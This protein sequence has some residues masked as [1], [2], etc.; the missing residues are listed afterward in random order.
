MTRVLAIATRAVETALIRRAGK[1]RPGGVCGCIVTVI[2]HLGSG[3]LNVYLHMLVLDGANANERGKLRFGPLP[4]SA[5]ALMTLL[6]ADNEEHEV[7]TAAC[8]A[9]TAAGLSV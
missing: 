5:P 1:T 4:P 8:K 9:C 3:S 7:G 2:Q 6:S